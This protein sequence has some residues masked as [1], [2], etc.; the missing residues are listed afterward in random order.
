[1]LIP[2][3]LIFPFVRCFFATLKVSED[4]EKNKWN[5]NND[6]TANNNFKHDDKDFSEK[7]AFSKT[8]MW[9]SQSP[10]IEN[11]DTVQRIYCL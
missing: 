5:L 10:Q 3:N 1:M 8:Q 11:E 6:I 9:L 4:E 2:E 7:K